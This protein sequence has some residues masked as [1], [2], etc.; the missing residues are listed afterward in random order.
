MEPLEIQ[1]SLKKKGITQKQLA[2]DLGVSE[3][4]ISLAVRKRM[5]SDRIMKAIA[6][7]VNEDHRYVFPEYYFSKNRHLKAA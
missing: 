4:A 2:D 7:A 1:F 5:V 6:E 3:M